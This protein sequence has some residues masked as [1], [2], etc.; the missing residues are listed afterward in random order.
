MRLYVSDLT[1]ARDQNATGHDSDRSLR[2]D[3][4][5]SR[6]LMTQGPRGGRQQAGG[7]AMVDH[8]A[9]NVSSHPDDEEDPLLRTAENDE[10]DERETAERCGAMG[11]EAAVE[12]LRLTQRGPSDD[13]LSTTSA[14][15]RGEVASA[16]G[17]ALTAGSP[18]AWAGRSWA[19]SSPATAGPHGSNTS[20]PQQHHQP[21]SQPF[22]GA[23]AT[24]GRASSASRHL[25]G[26]DTPP[27]PAGVAVE[28]E[29][30]DGAH[31][32]H[33]TN[34][35]A[36][37]YL[38]NSLSAPSLDDAGSRPARPVS[39]GQ[40]P[41]DHRVS[42]TRAG[43]GVDPPRDHHTGRPTG[44]DL[45]ASGGPSSY[46]AV[47]GDSCNDKRLYT[48][49]TNDEHRQ[50]VEVAIGVRS[51]VENYNTAVNPQSS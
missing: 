23:R 50:R 13:S 38:V 33:H 21:P 47:H 5:E 2:R 41:A 40:R 42:D 1:E 44:S 43:D 51:P 3:N 31:Q 6:P 32:W 15:S 30:P 4:S 12:Q 35:C 46:T 29:A 24:S 20:Q 11:G 48:N 8:R 16:R 49:P 7:D 36:S 18:A 25:P 28:Q 39:A 9:L 26:R 17:P 34:L 45:T 22:S 27:Q 14:S 10:V 19:P 37:G